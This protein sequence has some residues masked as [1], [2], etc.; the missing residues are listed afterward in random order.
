M[1]VVETVILVLGV[2]CKLFHTICSPLLI[3]SVTDSYTLFG[4][5]GFFAINEFIIFI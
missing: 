2:I 4:G 5:N 3:P 1:M